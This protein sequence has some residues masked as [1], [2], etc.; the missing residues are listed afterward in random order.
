MQGGLVRPAFAV[1]SAGI[2]EST[3]NTET[4]K[5]RFM[6]ENT[7]NPAAEEFL[8]VCKA[9]MLARGWRDVDFVLVTG[10]AYVDHPSFGAAIISRLLE[11]E[12][13]RVGVLSQ[14]DFT[15][16]ESM[17]EFGRPRYGFFIGGGNVDSMVA[18]Y[19]VG[20]ASGRTAAPPFTRSWQSRLTRIFR[21]FWEGWRR[22]FAALPTTT[23][24]WMMCCPASSR[25]AGRISFPSAWGNARRRRLHGDW[26]PGSRWRRSPALRGPVI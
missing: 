17:K 24:G 4:E 19:S 10:D 1:L 26:R 13:Y 5:D 6:S 8:P 16:C 15:T 20:Q 11:A 23:I 21:S 25:V 9:D 18:H 7:K 22:R 14:P 12:G 3:V 2:L